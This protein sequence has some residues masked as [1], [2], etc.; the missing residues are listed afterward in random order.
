MGD[1]IKGNEKIDYSVEYAVKTIV[2]GMRKKQDEGHFT[3]PESI[4]LYCISQVYR[5]WEVQIKP[6]WGK[7][8]VPKISNEDI[9]KELN[10]YFKV[11]FR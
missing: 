7:P 11:E 2:D 6:N 4:E 3:R 10:K 5:W 8:G 9:C 1:E